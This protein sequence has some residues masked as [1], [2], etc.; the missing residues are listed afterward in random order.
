MPEE[1]EAPTHT[2]AST[3]LRA[4]RAQLTEEPRP[5]S[6]RLIKRLT[7]EDRGPRPLPRPDTPD[8]VPP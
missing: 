1:A 4:L 3:R 6:E 2:A 7:T 8:F 5:L